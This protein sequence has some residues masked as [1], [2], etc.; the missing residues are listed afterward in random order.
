MIDITI[1]SFFKREVILFS[2]FF[3]VSSD[4]VICDF[5][6]VDSLQRGKVTEPAESG[7]LGLEIRCGR[8]LKMRWDYF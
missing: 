5:G 1:A 3:Q 7:R 6:I 2:R 4:N 8:H